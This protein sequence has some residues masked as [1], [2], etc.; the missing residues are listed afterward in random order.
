M[1]EPE[2]VLDQSDELKAILALL[3]SAG[4]PTAPIPN[5]SPADKLTGGLAWCVA[6]TEAD[7]LPLHDEDFSIRDK[8]Q[9]FPSLPSLFPFSNAG[10]VIEAALRSME[11]PYTLHAHQIRELDYK[12][13]YPA[14][15]W[16][17]GRVL[18]MQGNLEDKIEEE[19]SNIQQLGMELVHAENSIKALQASLKEQELKRVG[20]HSEIEHLNE[21]II[22]KNA[23]D[24]VKNLV[25][26]LQSLK[27]TV[28]NKSAVTG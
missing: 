12:S 13:I 19:N 1:A 14:V 10:E 6:S 15:K 4:Y 9:V 16:I 18:A 8:M 21:K 22:S 7:S 24:V 20:V 2:V 5:L 26:L 17:V 23:K 25:S 3:A 28:N 27:D 11:C